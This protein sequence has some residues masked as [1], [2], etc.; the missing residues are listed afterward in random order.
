MTYLLARL[1]M[2]AAQLRKPRGV[3]LL[4]AVGFSLTAVITSGW[5]AVALAVAAI[6]A[7]AGVLVLLSASQS[8]DRVAL[9]ELAGRGPATPFPDMAYG[10]TA[11]DWNPYATQR[12]RIDEASDVIARARATVA[13]ETLHRAPERPERVVPAPGS[14]LV[15]VVV[16]CFNEERFVFDALESIRRQWFTD[17]ECI[18][19]DDASTDGTVQRVAAVIESDP[20]FTLV[21]HHVNGG[22]SASRNTGLRLARGSLITFLDGDDM[23]MAASL[24]D[25]VEVMAAG[26]DPD[27]AG[28]FCGV[29]L[30]PESVTLDELPPYQRWGQREEVDFVSDG[31][32]CPFNAHAPLL[33]TSVVRRTG[34][35]DEKMTRGVEDWDLWYRLMRNGYRF[36]PS[37]LQTAVYRQK[38]AS[39]AKT[40]ASDHVATAKTMIDSAFA[41]VDDQVLWNTGLPAYELPWQEYRRLREHA[42]RTLQYAATALLHGGA[43][44]AEAILAEWEPLAPAFLDHHVRPDERIRDGFR[45][46]LGLDGVEIG[47]LERELEPLTAMLLDMLM[48]RNAV[49]PV[50]RPMLDGA[51]DI[52]FAVASADHVEPLTSVAAGLPNSI[53][54][55]FVNLERSSGPQ[56]ATAALAERG[57][58]ALSTDAFVLHG[59]TPRLLVTGRPVDPLVHEMAAIHGSTRIA[60][61][62]RPGDDVAELPCAAT[63]GG[64]VTAAS[65]ASAPAALAAQLDGVAGSPPA[66]RAPAGWESESAIAREEHIAFPADSERLAEFRDIHKGDRCVIIG[67]GPSLN[68]LD[69]RR[70]ADAH[71]FAVNGIFY[72][73]ERMGFAPTYYVVEDSSVMA[74]NTDAIKEYAAGHK[75]FPSIY[76]RYVGDV[77]GVS[78]FLMNRGFYEPSSPSYCVPKFS[79]DIAQRVYSG[80]SVTIINLQLAYYMGFSEVVLIGMDFSYTIPDGAK[81]EGDIITSTDD[82]PNHF[83]PEYFGK[84]KTWKDPKLDR[85]LA[86]YQLAK[87][88]YEAD[89]RRIVNATPGGKLELFDRVPYDELFD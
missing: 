20:R 32:R 37:T 78:Y 68:Q 36:V 76:R 22:L 39:M 35:F 66:A 51:V 59:P 87:R 4:L 31:F 8:E 77:P 3:L 70:L 72:A 13:S 5:L 58:D 14:P 54:R 41:A 47:E 86:N 75:F 34:G 82:D 81:V 1:R 27:V 40:H 25:R 52:A 17:W 65:V 43:A 55:T 62:D 56:G 26:I 67:N 44:S 46:A 38:S 15:T 10:R 84:G 80:Q 2:L 16:P 9:R 28:V 85:V 61:I 6:S 63:S 33:R 74:E 64:I 42:R 11:L 83:H 60:V 45:R 29:Q 19:V 57:V 18:V 69:L 12:R 7:V 30:M 48:T 23:L 49:S 53:T 24:L 50:S 89:G 79:T 73:S 21:R 71:T 88:I